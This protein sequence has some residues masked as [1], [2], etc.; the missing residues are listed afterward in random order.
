[1]R[2]IIGI[3]I[4][5]ALG[6]C[7]T[8]AGLLASP[9][10]DPTPSPEPEMV[11]YSIGDHF[12]AIIEVEAGAE[13]LWTWDDG[14]TSSATHPVKAY[15]DVSTD[16][17]RD[18]KLLVRPWS[19]LK[20]ID[21]CYDGGDGGWLPLDDDQGSGTE[22]LRLPGQAVV[23]IGNLGLAAPGLR[24]FAA[25]HTGLYSLDFSGFELLEIIE[26]YLATNLRDVG[27]EGLPALR[28]ACF[29]DCDLRELDLSG[30][31][32]LEDLRGALNAY[33]TIG[34]GGIGSEVWHICVR[35][36]GQL[37]DRYLFEDCSA[38]PN[39]RELYI[40]GDNQAG[41]I[42]I[43]STGQGSVGILAARNAYESLDLRGALADET[44]FATVDF[45]DNQ[46][47]SVDIEG[48]DQI[49]ELNLSGNSLPQSEVDEILVALDALGRD[50]TGAPE[51]QRFSV[52]LAGGG[53]AAPSAQGLEAAERLRAKGWTVELNG[54]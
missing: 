16:P 8:P 2:I 53:N 40:W 43:P 34:F 50:G 37:A 6:S 25:S 20:G 27:L 9:S 51:W 23:A 4:I 26:C 11:F 52:S 42:R 1:M 39:I 30:C 21:L 35:D 17:V 19:A 49:T 54:P 41:S 3:A 5:V 33:G 13:V 32:A 15:A 14:E 7:G 31:P 36:N 47:V 12:E 22:G 38:F 48:C 18:N 28:R 46:L 44:S 24:W 29:E 10:P 45:S